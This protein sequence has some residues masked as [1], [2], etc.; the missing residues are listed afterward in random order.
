M[1]LFSK[2]CFRRAIPFVLV[3]VFAFWGVSQLMTFSDSEYAEMLKKAEQSDPEA[4]YEI[5]KSLALGDF[6]A[7][8]LHEAIK[9]FERA[10]SLGHAQAKNELAFLLERGEKIEKDHER[11]LVL[12]AEAA[13]QDNLYA[14]SNLGRLYSEGKLVTKDEKLAFD[15]YLRAAELGFPLAQNMVGNKYYYGK[16][17]EASKSEAFKW[18]KKA[19]D[20]GHAL[21]ETAMGNHYYLGENVEQ[22]YIVAG[23]WYKRAALQGVV[24]AERFVES[25]VITCSDNPFTDATLISCMVGAGAG[26]LNSQ[27]KLGRLFEQ[28]LGVRR[29]LEV[30]NSWYKKAAERGHFAAQRLLAKNYLNGRGVQKD[31]VEGRAW[32]LVADLYKPRDQTEEIVALF[33]DAFLVATEITLSKEELR[34]AQSRADEINGL[35]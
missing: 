3:A 13:E 16:G 22:D 25:N 7:P 15:Y 24:D 8:N 29:S 31:V 30:A 23:Q 26:D 14:L 9:W 10:A 27:Y 4:Q 17:V 20:Q 1:K 35:K 18:H 19:A 6:T 32:L 11:A 21:A 28:G 12:F 34:E 2:A 33:I 5:A